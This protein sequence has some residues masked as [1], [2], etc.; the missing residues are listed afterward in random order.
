MYQSGT[1]V[2]RAFIAKNRP[3]GNLLIHK[4]IDMV[5][6]GDVIIVETDTVQQMQ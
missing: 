3:G 4:S 1:L 5:T 6:E 2:G